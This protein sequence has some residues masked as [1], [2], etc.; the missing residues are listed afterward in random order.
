MKLLQKD[1][2]AELLSTFLFA[3]YVGFIESI[4]ALTQFST[5]YFW[6]STSDRIGRKPV[7]LTGLL[8][9]FI[10]TNCYGLSK[11]FPQMIISR[12]IAGLMNANIGVL[13]SSLGEI[14]DETNQARAFSLIPLAFS[15]GSII[16]PSIGGKF[17]N[18]TE[19]FPDWF[20]DSTFLA[21][22]PYWL[23]CF[24]C[25]MFNLLGFLVGF[26]FLKETLPSKI[27][28]NE[29]KKAA[30]LQANEAS[31]E[32]R[33]LLPTRSA[34]AESELSPKP[35]LRE[36]LT[37]DV[38]AALINSGLMNFI[39]IT[40]ISVLPLFLYTT[41]STGGM[42]FTKEQIGYY[43]AANGLIII[44]VQLFIF[45]PLEKK[46]GGPLATLRMAC[47]ALPLTFLCF[48]IAHFVAKYYG[49]GPSLVAL[50]V[51]LLLRG[52][53]SIM[54]VSSNLCV[55]NVAPSRSALGKLNGLSQMLGCLSR[56]IG[57]IFS[58]SLFAY[59]ISHTY[60]FI[61]GQSVWILYAAISLVTWYSS[62]RMKNA[63]KIQWKGNR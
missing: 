41:V 55:N 32:R 47:T 9:T 25:S 33:P 38:V 52:C 13:K 40:Y 39:N 14:T 28:R 8:G 42:S 15:L 19:G 44:I 30:N 2:L 34:T 36:L 18:P 43:L 22:Y 24:M 49:F 51:L 53:S 10:S 59:S 23:P 35:T 4:F 26:L 11:T 29:A 3:D 45:P 27:R 46:M 62:S 12:S 63:N 20:G 1:S 37:A 58:T 21:K 56:G 54:V 61:D 5:V 7:L 17:S 6:G 57:P 31:Q 50:L 16:G 48:P 60:D